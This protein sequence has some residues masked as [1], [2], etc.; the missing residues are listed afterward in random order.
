MTF[1]MKNF[2]F[3]ADQAASEPVSGDQDMYIWLTADS[4][5]VSSLEAESYASESTS[6][7]SSSNTWSKSRQ[8]KSRGN[9]DTDKSRSCEN[10][11]SAVPPASE[12]M[13]KASKTCR[14]NSC[15]NILLPMG[16]RAEAAA[17]SGRT[18]PS[19]LT[20]EGHRWASQEQEFS[21]LE[22]KKVSQRLLNKTRTGFRGR[23][24]TNTKAPKILQ[25][26]KSALDFQSDTED[27]MKSAQL[28]MQQ[29]EMLRQREQ[30]KQARRQYRKVRKQNRILAASRS[31]NSGGLQETTTELIP[32]LKKSSVSSPDFNRANTYPS[33]HNGSN[34]WDSVSK[35]NNERQRL[36]HFAPESDPLSGM[37]I[38]VSMNSLDK[39]SNSYNERL[40]SAL[41]GN[42]VISTSTVRSQVRPSTAMNG[43][44]CL[45][46][47]NLLSLDGR[48]LTYQGKRRNGP[49]NSVADRALLGDKE[50]SACARR[51]SSSN[52]AADNHMPNCYQRYPSNPPAHKKSL[53]RL[54]APN[55]T[56]L[57]QQKFISTHKVF[58]TTSR[59]SSSV[60]PNLVAG[61]LT[62][63]RRSCKSPPRNEVASSMMN[64]K[65]CGV[66]APNLLLQ[67]RRATIPEYL[68]DNSK[69]ERWSARSTLP[70]RPNLSMNL[71]VAG[72][73][74]LWNSVSALDNEHRRSKSQAGTRTAELAL[75]L[76]KA[77]SLANNVGGNCR[78]DG[79]SVDM[80]TIATDSFG[81]PVK[82]KKSRIEIM[83][84][85][86]NSRSRLRWDS[87]S[88]GNLSSATLSD[89]R[90]T[91][92]ILPERRA[93]RKERIIR[94]QAK[95]A[96]R[97][98]SR[99]KRTST[100]ESQRRDQEDP[101]P[102]LKQTP[103]L[104]AVPKQGDTQPSIIKRTVTREAPTLLASTLESSPKVAARK[105]AKVADLVQSLTEMLNSSNS[106]M[107][108]ALSVDDSPDSVSK[109]AVSLAALEINR[110]SRM[111]IR[112]EGSDRA[113]KSKHRHAKNIQDEMAVVS[114]GSGYVETIPE[115]PSRKLSLDLVSQ[116]DELSIRDTQ[117]LEGDIFKSPQLHQK[118][119]YEYKI[120]RN[121]GSDSRPEPLARALSEESQRALNGCDAS[122]KL[123]S[124]NTANTSMLRLPQRRLSI[125][126]DP[127]NHDEIGGAKPG[128]TGQRQ[129]QRKASMDF[130]AGVDDSSTISRSTTF[131]SQAGGA[132]LL[133]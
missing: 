19:T 73:S 123:T 107:Q 34:R 99:P 31:D 90:S 43:R 70:K 67:Q 4:M 114:I 130:V 65:K 44:R 51:S 86:K 13:S 111:T 36:S 128:S 124:N 115:R 120:A 133:T 32:A 17:S 119:P 117:Y 33:I 25:S 121:I 79:L 46:N 60:S 103:C 113:L 59:W 81:K 95:K 16:K 55:L 11:V 18:K 61:K 74:T 24:D 96:D 54:S 41:L 129:P 112:E 93:S 85:E 1:D 39:S 106:E 82:G 30:Q 122:S 20:D 97:A 2:D 64:A 47:P 37:I 80:P 5:S 126:Y 89:H 42:M 109:A 52:F 127:E 22:E 27:I 15:P 75:K 132:S 26:T 45:S 110:C 92:K 84:E 94:K 50:D 104:P 68:L 14:H 87:G 101:L 78:V 71:L 125:T 77:T 3:E 57:D 29:R 49:R 76:M 23:N 131:S 118:V 10:Q 40:S 98:I 105:P 21:I 102:I 69:N 58:A 6:S 108:T 116:N 7:S 35:L 8:E 53:P 83:L 88:Y 28:Q 12:P 62:S 9:T 72:T 38:D 66:S 100:N 63:G 91:M 48:F 56:E